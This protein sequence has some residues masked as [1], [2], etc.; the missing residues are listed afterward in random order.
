MTFNPGDKVRCIPEV[1]SLVLDQI[2]TVMLSYDNVFVA[3][4]TRSIYRAEY[5]E[6]VEKGEQVK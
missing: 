2:L 5:F 1:K 4:E 3:E 6:L